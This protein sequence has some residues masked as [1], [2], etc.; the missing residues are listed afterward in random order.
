MYSTPRTNYVLQ[1]GLLLFAFGIGIILSFFTLL[2]LASLL[3]HAPQKEIQ[4]LLLRPEN[5]GVN[6]LLQGLG[7]VV[8][9][10]IPALVFARLVQRR[11]QEYLGFSRY[12]SGKQVFLVIM[13]IFSAILVGGAL[14]EINEHIPVSKAL[15][16]KFK[17][18]EDDYAK[19]IVAIA[20]MKNISEYLVS[21]FVLAFLPALTEELL[22]RGCMQQ[23][24]IGLTKRPLIGILITSIVFSLAHA[25]FY[26]FLP[27][28]FLG[29]VLGYLFYDSKNLWLSIW[30]HFFNNALSL[31]Q[32]YALS[33]SGRLTAESMND[34]FPVYIGVIGLGVVIALFYSF[35]KESSRILVIRETDEQSNNN[36]NQ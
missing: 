26:G 12:A 32:L 28:L 3:L 4:A 27:R 36:I 1:I 5:A 31:T 9:L 29:L 20:G 24:V 21:L 22:F 13:I 19:Q 14:A 30:A 11:P 6:R 25:S 17:A 2:P 8:S 35:R 7:G 15:T 23:V 18:L 33:R 16:L 10:G 34:S